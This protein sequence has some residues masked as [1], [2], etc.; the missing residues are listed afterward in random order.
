FAE[1]FPSRFYDV[2]I[3]EQHAVTMA[4][5]LAIAGRRPVVSLY[6]TF[7]QR[8]FDQL[9]HD[10][11]QNDLPVLVAMDRAGQVGE[12]GTSHQGMFTLPAQRSLPNLAIGSPKD[13]QELRDMVVTAFTHDGP[14]S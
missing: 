2:G 9:V 4:A 10:V 7:S 8:A 14:M 5:G 1:R 6:S 12:D 3:A 11:C 13:E